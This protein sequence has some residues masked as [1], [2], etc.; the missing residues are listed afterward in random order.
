MDLLRPGREV[1]EQ[2]R[3][4]PGPDVLE[5][6]GGSMEEFQGI[7]P[8]LHLDERAVEGKRFLHDPPQLPGGDILPEESVGDGHG[9][10]REGLAPEDFFR[11]RKDPLRHI[12]SAVFRKALDDSLAEGGERSAVVCAVVSHWASSLAPLFVTFTT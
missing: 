4:E 9:Y 10:L 8:R 1:P 12:E 7:D 3:H 2:P 6:E 11:N 5:R